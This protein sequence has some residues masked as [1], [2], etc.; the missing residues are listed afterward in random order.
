MTEDFYANPEHRTDMNEMLRAMNESGDDHAR[1]FTCAMVGN[2]TGP[3]GTHTLS[4]QR[5]KP[6]GTVWPNGSTAKDSLEDQY[7]SLRAFFLKPNV[8]EKTKD[9]GPDIFCIEG[10]ES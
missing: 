6:E 7:N 10:Y 2:A 1:L 5:G 9:I 3:E 4:I 8:Y